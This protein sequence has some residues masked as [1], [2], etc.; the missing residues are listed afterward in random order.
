MPRKTNQFAES[1]EDDETEV[2]IPVPEKESGFKQ[3]RIK[4]TWTMY[5]GGDMY[6]FVDGKTFNIP[7]E[8][9]DHLKNYGNIY[10]T[11]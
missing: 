5:W 10:D 6:N 1:V 11:L 4:G 7:Q 8:L 9:F 3:A 2:A